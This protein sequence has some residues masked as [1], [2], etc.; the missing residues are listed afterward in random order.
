[1]PSDA[2]PFP[3]FGATE[4]V[5]LGAVDAWVRKGD[6]YF[7]NGSYHMTSASPV[8]LFRQY[9]FPTDSRFLT[10]DFW[11]E[12]PSPEDEFLS[13]VDNDP[14]F[15]FRGD[16]FNNDW[17]DFLNSGPSDVSEFAGTNQWLT[18]LDNV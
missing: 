6:V 8:F 14:L 7:L 5:E 1:V 2:L 11:L 15:K 16:S 4:K 17:D 18:F 3:F 13:L 10:F 12:N 9:D